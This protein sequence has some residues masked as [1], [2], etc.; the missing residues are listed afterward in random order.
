MTGF[1]PDYSV[2][3]GK[4]VEEELQVHSIKNVDFAKSIGK[5]PKWVS[6]FISGKATLNVKTALEIEKVCR[7]DA[8]TLMNIETSHRIFEAR[9]HQIIT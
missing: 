2:T 7:L 3:V 6:Q 9:K 1:N 4:F 5:S 8:Q